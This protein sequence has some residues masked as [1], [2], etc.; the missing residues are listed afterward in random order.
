M[1]EGQKIGELR[2]F[3]KTVKMKDYV[4]IV[5]SGPSARAVTPPEVADAHGGLAC[6]NPRWREIVDGHTVILCNGAPPIPGADIFMCFDTNARSKG[7]WHDGRHWYGIPDR[8]KHYLIGWDLAAKDN[9]G[10]DYYTFE[11]TLSLYGI[12]DFQASWPNRHI[13]ES[14][15]QPKKYFLHGGA[16]ITA[17]A[18]QLAMHYPNVKVINL[19]GVE[20]D[21]AEKW[22][23]VDP[24]VQCEGGRRHGAIP[25][26]RLISYA[27]NDFMGYEGDEPRKRKI[28]TYHIGRTDLC[29]DWVGPE[30]FYD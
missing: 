5:G 15:R 26:N 2:D 29:C 30:D 28:Q 22:D 19:V 20:M 10:Q 8:A 27:C 7:K 21:G 14:P 24:D 4:L 1:T 25:F 16:T 23:M 6:G 17:C 11:W 18:Y 9:P 12:L 3:L 13:H